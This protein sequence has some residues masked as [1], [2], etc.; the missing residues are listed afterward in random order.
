MAENAPPRDWK[1]IARELA[2]A[3]SSS[4]CFELSQE[5]NKALAE[6]ESKGIPLFA[7]DQIMSRDHS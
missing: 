1:T 2:S 4:K 6:E 5:L 7:K 3:Q